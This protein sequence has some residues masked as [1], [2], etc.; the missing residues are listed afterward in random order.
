M[1]LT[2]R[3]R[4]QHRDLDAL[5][6]SLEAQLDAIGQPGWDREAL[7]SLETFASRLL[8]HLGMEDEA[9]Y[10]VLVR[11]RDPEVQALARR[12][13]QEMGGLKEAFLAYRAEWTARPD[14]LTHDPRRFEAETR[15]I[16]ATLARRMRA[17][18]LEL[19]PRA[20]GVSV[21]A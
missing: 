18:D 21:E 11:H 16:L 10:P 19:Y 6:R 3:Y 14:A 20:D 9:L 15:K 12:Y 7:R 17:E 2:A 1:P 13:Q 8:L 4:A 5:S